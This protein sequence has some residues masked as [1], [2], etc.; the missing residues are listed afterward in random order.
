MKAIKAIS[1]E[2]IASDIEASILSNQLS[3]NSNKIDDLVTMYNTVLSQLLDKHA[4]IRAC[5]VVVR[6]TVCALDD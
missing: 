5:T 6:N 3:E 2:Y 4:P 1:R